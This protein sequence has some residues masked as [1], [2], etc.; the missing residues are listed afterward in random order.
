MTAGDSLKVDKPPANFECHEMVIEETLNEPSP[1]HYPGYLSLA[2]P[3]K[4]ICAKLDF[5]HTTSEEGFTTSDK[6]PCAR[7]GRISFDIVQLHIRTPQ[8]P[9]C[10]DIRTRCWWSF[11][12][13]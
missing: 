9:L 7:Y 12:I 2:L 1:T 8:R 3:I 13:S 10:A 4:G 6:Q 11:S 5:Q